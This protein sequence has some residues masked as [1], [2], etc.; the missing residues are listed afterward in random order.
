MTEKNKIKKE[1]KALLLFLYENRD[2][3]LESANLE[4]MEDLRLLILDSKI[5]KKDLL[6]IF[7]L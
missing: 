2:D 1:V 4:Y 5:S 6:D 3:T 7:G